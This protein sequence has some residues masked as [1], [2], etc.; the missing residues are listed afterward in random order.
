MDIQIRIVTKIYWKKFKT[1]L[2]KFERDKRDQTRHEPTPTFYPKS[3]Y[4]PKFFY[5]N[6]SQK[7]RR[8]FQE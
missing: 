6:T 3:F 5:E 8:K 7:K 1:K 4:Y 2:N